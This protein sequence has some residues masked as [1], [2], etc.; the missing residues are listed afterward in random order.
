MAQMTAALASTTRKTITYQQ[1]SPEQ[2]EIENP[3]IGL[4]LAK[5]FAY[6]VE[7]GF[8]GDEQTMRAKDLRVKEDKLT[9]FE[10]FVRAR[11]WTFLFQE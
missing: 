1:I 6:Q 3:G 2:F 5:M 8:T 10:S 7:Y 9:S 11:D 4:M